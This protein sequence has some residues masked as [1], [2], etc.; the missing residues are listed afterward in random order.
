[1]S[2][3]VGLLD[4]RGALIVALCLYEVGLRLCFLCLRR[5]QRGF[6]ALHRCDVLRRIDLEQ[7]LSLRDQSAFLHREADD[8]AADVRG[9][10]DLRL[11]LHLAACRHGR[12]EIAL[13]HG[14]DAHFG[15][16]VAALCRGDGH[17]RRDPE[18]HDAANGPLHPFAHVVL[19]A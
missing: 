8:A 14:L 3:R 10:V 19:Y 13:L 4:V 15:A 9:D 17:E 6:C 1:M 2:C 5:A 16:L 18:D 11:R 7:E 12:D